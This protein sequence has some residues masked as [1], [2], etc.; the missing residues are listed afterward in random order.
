MD[1]KLIYI[2]SFEINNIKDT[3]DWVKNEEFQRLFMMREKPTWENHVK[4]FNSILNDKSQ[5]VFAIYYQNKHVGNCGLKN[6]SQ[7]SAELWIYIGD[8]SFKNKGIGTQATKLLI[9]K[10]FNCFNLHSIYLHVAN[11]NIY[12]QKMYKNIGFQEVPLDNETIKIWGNRSN[13]LRK[14]EIQK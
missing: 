6:I 8:I 11:F 10:G 12:A 1:E 2:K 4:Y 9:D 13:T 7:H 3:F 5:K 14:M